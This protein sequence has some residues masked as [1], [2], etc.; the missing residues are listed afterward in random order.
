MRYLVT[1]VDVHGRSYIAHDVER[2]GPVGEMATFEIYR[3]PSVPGPALD[4]P[5][6]QLMPVAPPTGETTWK[7]VEFPPGWNYHLHRSDSVDFSAVVDGNVLFSVDTGSRLLG[8]GDCVLVA[9]TSHAWHSEGG[10]RLL[11]AMLG[12]ART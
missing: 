2:S 9:G 12:G 1:A 4:Q 11:V 7:V 5:S 8:P 6:A 10:C 3:G